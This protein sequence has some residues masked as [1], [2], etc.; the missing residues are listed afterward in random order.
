MKKY[1]KL[2]IPLSLIA[3]IYLVFHLV[4][5]GC[6]IKFVSGISCPGCGMT[7]ALAAVLRGDAAS[8]FSFHPLWG[9]LPLLLLLLPQPP[10][11]L[12]ALPVS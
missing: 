6:P 5:I 8:A 1:L 9:T 2:L 11:W 10:C 7:R 3:L 12:P 4:G